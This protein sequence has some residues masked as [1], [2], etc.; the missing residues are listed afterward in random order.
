MTEQSFLGESG[1]VNFSR[2][3]QRLRFTYEILRMTEKPM[4]QRYWEKVG[5]AESTKIQLDSTFWNA[6]FSSTS[7]N[8]VRMATIEDDPVIIVSR[9]SLKA[10]EKMYIITVVY[11]VQTR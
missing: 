9:E 2:D 3:G 8:I 10:N 11:Q 5:T 1:A 6:N 4:G 7:S